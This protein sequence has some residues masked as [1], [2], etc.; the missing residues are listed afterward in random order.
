MEGVGK[1]VNATLYLE[2]TL[3]NMGL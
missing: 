1:H 3:H 2:K